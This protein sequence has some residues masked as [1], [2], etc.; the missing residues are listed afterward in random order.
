MFSNGQKMQSPPKDNWHL[1][2]AIFFLLVSPVHVYATH[3]TLVNY[4]FRHT[5]LRSSIQHFKC[6]RFA[7]I[8]HPHLADALT[9]GTRHLLPA[10]EC[11]ERTTRCKQLWKIREYL[12]AY[13]LTTLQIRALCRMT[14]VFPSEVLNSFHT[15]LFFVEVS[16]LRLAFSNLKQL[17]PQ[18]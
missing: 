17:T 6:V 7:M 13:T 3:T 2:Y 1:A 11:R 4:R 12:P 14:C 9:Y 10:G 16:S 8:V 18:R 5:Q 15:R